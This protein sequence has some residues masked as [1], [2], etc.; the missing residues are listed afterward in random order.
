MYCFSRGQ[1][2][3]H[4]PTSSYDFHDIQLSSSYHNPQTM[5]T[6]LNLPILNRRTSR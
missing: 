6:Q 5:S 1:L 4:L 2:S 3:L